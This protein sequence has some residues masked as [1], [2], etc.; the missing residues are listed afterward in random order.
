MFAL[1]YWLGSLEKLL[2][3][4]RYTSFAGAL[5]FSL[6]YDRAGVFTFCTGIAMFVADAIMDHYFADHAFIFNVLN[7]FYTWESKSLTLKWYL[8]VTDLCY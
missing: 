2:R 4:F 6:L 5:I 8:K 7:K 1:H 3:N